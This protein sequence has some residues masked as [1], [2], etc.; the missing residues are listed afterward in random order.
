MGLSFLVQED[1]R[2]TQTRRKRGGGTRLKSSNPNTEGGEKLETRHEDTM[3]TECSTLCEAANRKAKHRGCCWHP[4]RARQR[5]QSCSGQPD[6][7]NRGKPG[8]FEQPNRASQ[9]ESGRP[10]QAGRL[11]Q[12][13]RP[14]ATRADKSRQS[15]RL[16]QPD[17]AS[18]SEPGCSAGRPGRAPVHA[19]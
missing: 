18:Q 13:G 5:Q 8:R 2:H 17:R 15:G 4:N 6:P 14:G 7:A 19:R 10:R 9:G 12:P 1:A 3:Q 16:G 11:S